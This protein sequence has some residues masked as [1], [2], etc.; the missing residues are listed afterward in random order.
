[1]PHLTLGPKCLG[2][3]THPIPPW[4]WDLRLTSLS[5]CWYPLN[6]WSGGMTS[7][8]PFSGGQQNFAAGP[9]PGGAG[10]TCTQWELDHSHDPISHMSNWHVLT[11]TWSGETFVLDHRNSD[12]VWIPSIYVSL[13]WCL[14]KDSQVL[15]K[16][17]NGILYVK[18]LNEQQQ[19]QQ[20]HTRSIRLWFVGPHCI[21]LEIFCGM[22]CVGIFPCHTPLVLSE[23]VTLVATT[24]MAMHHTA[25]SFRVPFADPEQI[26]GC[27]AMPQSVERSCKLWEHWQ[28]RDVHFS[29]TGTFLN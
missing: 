19:T 12:W 27:Y 29:W 2:F 28:M 22:I 14:K 17:K 6:S 20:G 9:P 13:S 5:S 23:V 18:N 26:Q 11:A 15:N 21:C 24:C 25:E 4:E 10:G 16:I 7:P 1:M 3:T 8:S